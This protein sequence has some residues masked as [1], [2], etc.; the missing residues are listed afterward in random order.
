M[1]KIVSASI[2]ALM[3]AGCV[4]S[5]TK[6]DPSIVSGFQPGIT[7]LEQVK[8]KLGEPNSVTKKPDGSTVA[9]YNFLHGQPSGTS[10]IPVV[11]AFVGHSDMKS[12]ITELNFDR[13]GKFI[14]STMTEGQS[15]M[16][17]N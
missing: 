5:G 6:V 8:T 11:G 12:Q 4:T 7:T 16:G 17:M 9:F 15:S 10:F 2:V 1:R 13:N 3:L 14:N